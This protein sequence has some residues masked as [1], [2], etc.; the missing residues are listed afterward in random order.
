MAALG[1]SYART[2]ALILLQRRCKGPSEA[3]EVAM[4]TSSLA[5]KV[6]RRGEEGHALI[7]DRLAHPQVVVQPLLHARGVAELLGLHTGTER[8]PVSLLAMLRAFR[9]VVAERVLVL[10]L[11]LVLACGREGG[12]MLC[13]ARDWRRRT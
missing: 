5:L 7:H 9:G 3:S 1:L 2:D 11:V 10:V 12:C 13:A 8:Q 6:R 4:A